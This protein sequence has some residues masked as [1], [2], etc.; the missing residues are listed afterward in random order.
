MIPPPGN[1][2]AEGGPPAVIEQQ[3]AIL[4]K[5]PGQKVSFQAHLWSCLT[6][7]FKETRLVT[8]WY[9]VQSMFSAKQMACRLVLSCQKGDQERSVPLMTPSLHYTTQGN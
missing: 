1:V 4:F 9:M 5:L 7:V 2:R 6:W 3:E 8:P